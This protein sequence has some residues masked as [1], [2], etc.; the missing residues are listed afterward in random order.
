M[1][2]LRVSWM[3]V[4]VVGGALTAT[5]AMREQPTPAD[6]DFLEFLGSWQTGDD[7]WIDPFQVDDTPGVDQGDSEQG[8]PSRNDREETASQSASS[9]EETKRSKRDTTVPRRGVKP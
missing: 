7:R 6:A 9:G 2:M 1:M 5:A 8:H 3:L 4:A